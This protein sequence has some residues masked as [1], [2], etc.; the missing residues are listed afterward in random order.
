MK[1]FEVCQKVR[2]DETDEMGI[3]HHKNY[4]SWLELA[5][6]EMLEAVGLKYTNLKNNH[7][8]FMVRK[9]EGTYLVPA[10]FGDIILIQLKLKILKKSLFHFSSFIRRQIDYELLFEGTTT[11]VLTRNMKILLNIPKD[12]SPAIENFMIEY[13]WI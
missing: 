1:Y 6:F 4:F 12:I 2:F 11:H 3:V 13:G 7:I 8:G 10:K 5:R 9:T